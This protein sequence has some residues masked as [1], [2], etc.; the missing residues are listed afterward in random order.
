M[1]GDSTAVGDV[2][3]LFD[4]RKASIAFTDPPYNVGLGDHGGQRQG[5]RRRRIQNDALPD[6]EWEQF[7]R[8]WSR[9]LLN[10]VDGALYICMSTKE[11]PVV[12]RALEE[13]GGHWS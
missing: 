8:D 9:N 2:D 10:H 13:E 3:R 11:W 4:R 5:S 7:V 12:S 6:A 1:C